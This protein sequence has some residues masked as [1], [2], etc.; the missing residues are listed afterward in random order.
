[1]AQKLEPNLFRYIWR[2][3]R[4]EQIII[5]CMVVAALPIYFASLN[6]PRMIVNG[7]IA[8]EGYAA[9]DPTPLF[10]RIA[11]PWGGGEWVLFEGVALDRVGMLIA[12][13]FVF[14]GLV[15]I[16]GLIKFAINTFKGLMG[17][18][19]LRRLRY[20]LIDRV[21]RFPTSHFRRVKSSEVA[22]MVKDE[23]EPLGGFIGDAFVLPLYQV[24]LAATALIF[25]MAQS[26][27][28]GI[29]AFAVVLVQT[30]LIPWL[31]KPILQLGR[32]R[33][34]AARDLAVRVAEMVDGVQEIRTNDT[35][36]F[37]RADITD[38]L[39]RI[40]WIRAELFQRKFFVKFLNNF[41]SQVTPFLFY[42]VG[43]F[44]VI[45]NQMD[46]GQLVAVI[47][48]Y[49]DLPGPIKELINWDH[50]RADVQIKYEQVVD[51][52]NPDGLL[53]AERQSVAGPNAPSLDGEIRMQSVSLIDDSGA[54]FVENMT[55]SIPPQGRIGVVGPLGGGKEY[56]GPL[57]ARIIPPTVGEITVGQE[58]LQ[59]LPDHVVGRRFA[60]VGPDAFL[61]PHSV[62][63]NLLHVLRHEPVS[64]EIPLDP[65][66]RRSWDRERREAMAAGNAPF[67]IH[68]DWIDY[69]AIAATG[70]NDLES[71]MLKVADLVELR[72]DL[73]E[74]GLHGLADPDRFPGVDERLVEAR[75][76]IAARLEA[77]TQG[78][79]IEL[80]EPGRFNRNATIGENILFGMPRGPAFAPGAIAG[81]PYM[82]KIL[83]SVG[84]TDD[85]MAMGLEIATTMV[86]IFADLPPDHEFFDQFSF[87]SS[88][89]LPDF[90]ALTNRLNRA[91]L[92]AATPEERARLKAL[93][94][95]YIETRHRLKLITPEIEAKVIAAREAFAAR[96]PE[97]LEGTVDFFDP[98]RYS[99]S[100]SVLDNVLLG[101]IAYGQ[102]GAQTTVRDIV[103]CVLDDLD[104]TQIVL[105]LGLDYQ[106]GTGGRRLTAA[107]R[108]K[109]ALARALLKR[110]DLL[111]V[112]LALAVFDGPTQTRIL[113]R[114][115]G[116][117]HVKRVVW[118]LSRPDLA[119]GFDHVLV[120][121]DGHIVAQGRYD[122]LAQDSAGP[123]ERMLSATSSGRAR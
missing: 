14:L 82:K 19:L 111:I 27:S 114:V 8:G 85:L 45:R 26:V 69:N 112:D 33:Q 73:Y 20:E 58:D 118:T 63:D 62:R 55:F 2:H 48:A 98:E 108:Q 18:R 42:L 60:Y 68:A 106:V 11:V 105:C 102:A 30:F 52:F 37:A 84:L 97:D 39:G 117:D 123:L 28:L 96:L 83:E 64:L 7:P 93:P 119:R 80:F 25:I 46:I 109:L 53:P 95:I 113:E 103:S 29:L 41:L 100:A 101:R 17:E 1:M 51:H 36:N 88:R 31:R 50:Q 24:G 104:L 13:A 81:H 99:P 122:T 87:I 121:E 76:Q 89:S 49:K 70:P 38:R 10:G 86:E 6:L 57:L 75:H 43:G 74:F 44:L 47:A 90:Q 4:R 91:G 34:L 71:H 22:S 15:L 59:D 23:V 65:A 21:L 5:L 35:T 61:F 67:T 3:S 115:M 77:E 9:Q 54:R 78:Q 79:L 120:V 56:L 32:Q 72:D 94:F 110:S 40:F 66:M 107:Q 92:E 16:N 116:S 12:L